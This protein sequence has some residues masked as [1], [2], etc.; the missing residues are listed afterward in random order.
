V[1]DRIDEVLDI[2]YRKRK[3]EKVKNLNFES[4]V[5]NINHPQ[6]FF[7]IRPI[8]DVIPIGKCSALIREGMKNN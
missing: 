6:D 1:R 2:T 8:I 3:R 7:N 5:I 4:V